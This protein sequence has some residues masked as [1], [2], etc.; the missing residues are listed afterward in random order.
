MYF[1]WVN[2]QKNIRWIRRLKLLYWGKIP[3]KV[4][5]STSYD[6]FSS[7]N[8]VERWKLVFHILCN[9]AEKKFFFLKYWSSY[10][11]IFP[12]LWSVFEKLRI[13]L[14][15]FGFFL[16]FENQ[17]ILRLKMKL[18][19]EELLCYRINLKDMKRKTFKAISFN[20]WLHLEF[21]RAI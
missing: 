18:K 4:F 6:N 16:I 10:H 19:R 3:K 17:W 5:P 1:L 2:K 11:L 15:G 7:Q 12:F 21:L 14:V 13:A 20:S 8:F 9:G